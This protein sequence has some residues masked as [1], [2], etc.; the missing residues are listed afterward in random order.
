MLKSVVK[1]IKGMECV[2]SNKY[3]CFAIEQTL[4]TFKV[5]IKGAIDWGSE[6]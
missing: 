4:T 6:M 2:C 5:K 3:P 1:V